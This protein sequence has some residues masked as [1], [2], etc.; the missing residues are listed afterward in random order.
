MSTPPQGLTLEQK[1][2]LQ[3]MR[4]AV[5]AMNE[6]QAKDLLLQLM[7]SFMARETMYRH[8]LKDAW[9]IGG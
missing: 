6:E 5:A 2:E 8:F 3:K 4:G 7:E 1:F 9:G